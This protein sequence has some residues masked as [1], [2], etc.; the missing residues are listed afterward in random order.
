LMGATT[1]NFSSL[2]ISN[3]YSDTKTVSMTTSTNANGGY[4]ILAKQVSALTSGSNTIS[5]FNGGTYAAPDTW[6]AGDRGFGYTDDDVLVNGSNRYQQSTTCLGGSGVAAPGCFAP[7]NT[8]A[9]EIIADDPGPVTSKS[10]TLTL[11][12]AVI[13]QF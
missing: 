10:Y 11:N 3:S 1:V 2:N 12:I 4:Q 5:G 6:L 13:A 7:F 9:Y 8:G